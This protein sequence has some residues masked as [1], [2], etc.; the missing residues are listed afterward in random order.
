MNFSTLKKFEHWFHPFVKFSNGL[1]NIQM[2]MREFAKTFKCQCQLIQCRLE[3]VIN[4][5]DIGI[6]QCAG[7]TC[8]WEI[9]LFDE[10]LAYYPDDPT[11]LSRTRRVLTIMLARDY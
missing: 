7:E 3:T 4:A 6:F 8:Y 10:A 5:F 1:Q 2:P 9:D 11:D